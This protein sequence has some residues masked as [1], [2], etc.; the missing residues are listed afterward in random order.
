MS[1]P[2]ETT[3]RPSVS[4]IQQPE[5]NIPSLLAPQRHRRTS[6][7]S[8]DRIDGTKST[9]SRRRPGTR[10][11]TTLGS[12]N[13]SSYGNS[14]IM[15]RSISPSQMSPDSS[16]VHYTRTGRISKAKKGLKVHHCDC[17]RSYTRA[18]HLRRHQR[19]HAQDALRCDWPGCGKP[20]YRLDLLQRHQERHNE[21]GR[22]ESPQAFSPGST[23]E[24]E[25]QVSASVT[26]PPP[27]VTA[28]PQNEPYYPQPA[29]PIPVSAAD[30]S[31]SKRASYTA[32]HTPGPVAVPVEGMQ[33]GIA[34]NDPFSNSPNYNSSSSE[35]ASPI[36][37]MP[38]YSTNMFANP[39]YGQGSSRTRTSSNAS[40]IEP[41]WAYPSRSPTSAT[42]TMA[43]TWNSNEKSPAPSNLAYMNTSYPMTSMPM[44]A[45]V[46]PMTGFGHFGPKTLLQR[47]EEEQAFL[48][49]EQSYGMGQL[50][51]TYPFEHYLNNY[52]R[53]FHTA[54]PI[55]HRATFESLNQS[56]MLHAAMIA[57]GGQYSN[58]ASVKRKS[59]ILHDRCMKLLDKRE[60]DVMTEADRICDWQALFLVEVLSQYRARRAAKTLSS[61]F[62]TLYQKLCDSF[63]EVTTNIVNHVSALMQ[64]ENA[65]YERWL[66]WIE[67]STQQRLF[68][69]CYILEYQQATLLTRSPQQS[70]ISC[71]GVELPLPSHSELWD[72]TTPSDWAM[73]SQQN[74]HHATFVYQVSP[75]LLQTF[76]TFQS[77]LIIAA[78]YNHFNNN[79]YFTPAN[80]SAIEHL[81]DH[82]P[83]TKHQLL[84]AKLLQ[85]VPIR[86]LLAI[87]GES[88][89]LSEKVPSPQIF[90]SYRTSLR[91]WVN[92]LW[93][94][95]DDSRGQPVKDA[96]KYA[97]EIAQHAMTVP[98]HALRLELGA[99]MGLYYAA[100]T[101]WATTVAANTRINAPQPAQ[102]NRFQSHSPLPATRNNFSSTPTSFSMYTHSATPNPNHPAALGLTS[103]PVTSPV[104]P[105]PS[106]T[107]MQYSELAMLSLSFL[108][109]ALEDHSLLGVAPHWP[110]DVSQWQQGC[111]ALMR[112]VKMRLRNGATE[113]R[114]SVVASNLHVGI[115]GTGRG[116]DGFGE[117]L[118]GVIGVLE[119]IMSRGW[120]GWG[121]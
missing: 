39:P 29:S 44:S 16:S 11:E 87:S 27:I 12:N 52:W 26:L 65:T 59:R 61:R 46:D 120:E 63:R 79:S 111:A 86:A 13:A 97:I 67:F 89:I 90:G 35:Y 68:L 95:S 92:G 101:I 8:D 55:V 69:C 19:N 81:L 31:N 47:D 117:L 70:S 112:W 43:Y 113:G 58:D 60:L 98:A 57:I 84:T 62:E 99:D 105:S 107:S 51:H 66:Q 22:G 17:G 115:A 50:A 49:P 106:T 71:A 121:F 4:S 3:T 110:R 85:V 119:K 74:P 48:F 72:A 114:D 83:I 40:Y 36:P 37:S 56:P 42:S 104:P 76:D 23:A 1:D 6:H 28:L 78:Y 53:Y 14:S 7:S 18:E 88:W 38:D 82:S 21:P 80:L 45:V 25:V 2:S 5:D 15:Q 116:G 96:L 54:Y 10:K 109:T 93:C 64:P 91:T 102:P 100:L 108:G 77:S 20:F 32:H 103:H 24:P 33:N 75:D 9:S 73:A 94:T 41:A 34:W 30:A 118:D